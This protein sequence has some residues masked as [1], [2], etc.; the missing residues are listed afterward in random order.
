[1]MEC[2]QYMHLRESDEPTLILLESPASLNHGQA[3]DRPSDWSILSLTISL[4]T[5]LLNSEA[6]VIDELLKTT[7]RQLSP[8]FPR[9]Y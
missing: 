3:R 2:H 7:S 1:M 4:K 5:N 9:L 6:L 8:T